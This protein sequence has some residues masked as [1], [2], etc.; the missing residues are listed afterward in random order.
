MNKLIQFYLGETKPFMIPL[1]GFYILFNLAGI[2]LGN[3]DGLTVLGLGIL[4]IVLMIYL[5]KFN[6]YD[7]G[8][9]TFTLVSMTD[10]SPV[11]ILM[12][13]LIVSYI[14][15]LMIVII[16]YVFLLIYQGI[17]RGSINIFTGGFVMFPVRALFVIT[18]V[19]CYISYPVIWMKIFK[20]NKIW[21][22]I[23]VAATVVAWFMINMTIR[24]NVFIFSMNTVHDG[25][26]FGGSSLSVWSVLWHLTW[27]IVFFTITVCL[28]KKKIDQI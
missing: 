4:S 16:Q 26:H 3:F 1:A 13:K 6:L 20:I 15:V 17:S 5:I 19:I 23:L 21:R 25:R 9:E 18:I 8:K 22:K 24:N 10:N 28:Q 2:I 12:S 27:C 7:T 14:H 11:S